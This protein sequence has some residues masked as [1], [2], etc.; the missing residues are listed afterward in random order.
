MPLG[1]TEG[2]TMT[3]PPSPRMSSP[4]LSLLTVLLILISRDQAKYKCRPL[5]VPTLSVSGRAFPSIE[6]RWMASSPGWPSTS[7]TKKFDFGPVIAAQLHCGQRFSH[8]VRVW[9]TTV[10]YLGQLFIRGILSRV[11]HGSRGQP[12]SASL[13]TCSATDCVPNECSGFVVIR[14]SYQRFLA[15]NG[16]DL[17]TAMPRASGIPCADLGSLPVIILDQC[18]N[19][20]ERKRSLRHLAVVLLGYS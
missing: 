6:N 19:R 5:A 10:A 12:R 16:H 7:R 1:C 9:G 3:Y 4:S 17:A 14:W 8:C 15:L 20:T 13:R 2:G 18:A 11:T